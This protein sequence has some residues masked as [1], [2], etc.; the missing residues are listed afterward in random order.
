MEH[1]YTGDTWRNTK[2]MWDHYIPMPNSPKRLLAFPNIGDWSTAKNKWGFSKIYVTPGYE[3][4]A[5]AIF[6]AANVMLALSLNDPNNQ[7]YVQNADNNQ[8]TNFYVDEPGRKGGYDAMLALRNIVWGADSRNRLW[9]ADYNCG[10]CN[11]CIVVDGYCDY[12]TLSLSNYIGNDMYAVTGG[13]CGCDH[14]IT[15]YGYFRDEF[16]GAF[17]FAWIDNDSLD[18]PCYA[19][20]FSWLN[21][22]GVPEVWWYADSTPLESEIQHF[23]DTAY[24]S[25]WL[26]RV[27]QLYSDIYTCQLD[28]VGFH[29][30]STDAQYYGVW[31]GSYYAGPVDPA[32][33]NAQLCWLLTSE[34]ATGEYSAPY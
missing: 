10:A 14:V 4:G 25:G 9:A 7:T 1:Y 16:G 22:N 12:M 24:Q 29:P 17:H 3:A 26:Q 33:P 19:D 2:W 8:V 13:G 28:N 11:A 15:D 31:N 5:A 23:T 6:G 32:T 21:S 30:P 18:R 34:T 27:D 20:F